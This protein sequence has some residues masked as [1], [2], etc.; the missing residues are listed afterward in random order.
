MIFWDFFSKKNEKIFVFYDKK[1]YTY[2]HEGFEWIE[3]IQMSWF[4]L[5]STEDK[6]QR[7]KWSIKNWMKTRG[8]MDFSLMFIDS[9]QTGR[10]LLL[11]HIWDSTVWGEYIGYKSMLNMKKYF[12][13]IEMI[14]ISLLLLSARRVFFMILSRV[15]K[16]FQFLSDDSRVTN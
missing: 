2:S 13:E 16:F 3:Y 8:K 10:N 12:S 1:L 11:W 6:C 9:N 15:F 7:R 14:S 4:F 5:E